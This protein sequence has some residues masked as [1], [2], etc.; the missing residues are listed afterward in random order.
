[1]SSESILKELRATLSAATNTGGVA[2][3]YSAVE[4]AAVIDKFIVD[5]SPKFSQVRNMIPRESFD[6]G[7]YIW[8]VRTSDNSA[9]AWGIS[10]SESAAN[11]INAAAGAK[12]QLYAAIKSFAIGWEVENFFLSISRSQYDAVVDEIQNAIAKAI[13]MEERQVIGGTDTGAY[14]NASGFLGLKQ[15]LNSYVTLSDTTT[16]F[17]TARGSGKTYMDCQLVN[18]ANAALTI[19]HLDSA[20]DALTAVGGQAGYFLTSIPMGSKMSQLLQSQQR[21]VGTMNIAGGF[22]LQTYNGVPIVR[23]K[24]MDK[25]GSS[26]TDTAF[27]LIGANNLVMKVVKE[28]S[29]KDIDLGRYDSVGGNITMYEVLVAKDLT[30]NVLVYGVTTV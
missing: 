12:K 24:Y 8:N 21:F 15:L 1:M 17:G 9:G 11:T 2:P 27:A 4:V 29:N 18:V 22:Q 10:A 30:K 28:L 26:D 13:D 7:A 20:V 3:G 14:G 16:V 23:S 19:K 5:A 25:F 6:Q